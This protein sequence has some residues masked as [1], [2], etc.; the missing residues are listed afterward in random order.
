MVIR[1]K[2]KIEL[3]AGQ[4]PFQSDPRLSKDAVLSLK[5]L[6]GLASGQIVSVRGH[7]SRLFDE[8]THTTRKGDDIPQREAVVSDDHTSIRLVLYDEGCKQI[9]QDQSYIFQN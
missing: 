3:L 7:V 2:S 5:D 9:S 8:T 1:D 4:P 6:R